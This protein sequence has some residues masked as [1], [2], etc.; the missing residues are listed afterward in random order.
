[1][2]KLLSKILATNI[3]L[4]EFVNKLSGV[5]SM[6]EEDLHQLLESYHNEDQISIIY[7]CLYYIYKY[8]FLVEKPFIMFLNSIKDEIDND[9]TK[10]LKF[11]YQLNNVIIFQIDHLY[12]IVNYSDDSIKVTLP[13]NIQNDYQFCVNCNHELYF[14]EQLLL[15]PYEFYIISDIK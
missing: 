12:F 14:K 6:N 7:L 3:N 10:E 9:F 5:S 8:N 11:H 15:E 4:S 2:N 1:M 13:N